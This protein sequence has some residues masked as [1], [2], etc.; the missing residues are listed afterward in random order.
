MLRPLLPVRSK[1]DPNI[2]EMPDPAKND[3]DPAARMEDMVADVFST[4]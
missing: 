2:A 3:D 4:R 1:L